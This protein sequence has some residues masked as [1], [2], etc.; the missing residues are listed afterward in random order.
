MGLLDRL[1][2]WFKPEPI[3]TLEGLERFLDS[4]AA[5]MAQ[6]CVME[7]CRARSGVLWQKLFK[8]QA[9]LAALHE[10]RWIT[11]SIAYCDLAEMVE[12]LLRDR[13]SG[14][15]AAL[16][17]GLLAMAERTFARHGLPAGAPDDFWEKALQRLE[18]RLAAAR[19]HEPKPVREIPKTDME[20]VFAHLPIH[21]SLRGHDYQLVQNHLRTNIV[22]I[23]EDFLEA[24]DLDRLAEAV[25]SE[26]TNGA[27]LETGQAPIDHL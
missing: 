16:S 2:R 24:A 25:V 13:H 21:E 1:S 17:Q 15:P 9:F 3:D 23:Y 6:K 12:G 19:L 27:P 14:P 7:Y 5:F 26:G 4:R 10:S 11:Y 22:R 18:H 20:E 8:E